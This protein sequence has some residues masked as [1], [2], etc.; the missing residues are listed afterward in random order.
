ME[1]S[2]RHK[3]KGSLNSSSLNGGAAKQ[4]TRVVNKPSGKRLSS[5][6]EMGA[7]QCVEEIKNAFRTTESN[8]NNSDR[9][10]VVDT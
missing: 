8:N 6:F 4:S 9:N 1:K 10:V 5:Q 3:S 2:T 7:D